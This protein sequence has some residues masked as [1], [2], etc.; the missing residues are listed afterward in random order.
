MK[1]IA[2]AAALLLA[3]VVPAAA[4]AM[5]IDDDERELYDNSIQCMTYFGIRAGMGGDASGDPALAKSGN[6][7]L[8]VATVLADEDEA[9]ID[10]DFAAQMATF[11]KITAEPDNPGNIQ[12]LR[13]I[14]EHCRQME[15]LV[16]AMVEGSD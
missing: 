5:T 2:W 4:T 1:K 10:R 16:D 11:R 7:F 9:Q 8:A 3:G 12:L 6:K 13:R 14:D 15:T